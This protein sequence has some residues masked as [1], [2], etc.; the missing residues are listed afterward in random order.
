MDLSKLSYDE[1]IKKGVITRGSWNDD[2]WEVVD[3]AKWHRALDMAA[4]FHENAGSTF[5][6][7]SR[8]RLAGGKETPYIQLI[9]GVLRII[10]NEAKCTSDDFLTTSALYNIF[11]LTD[12]SED[13]V[14][15]EFGAKTAE[16]VKVLETGE[17]EKLCDQMM[18]LVKFAE[19][20]GE[21]QLVSCVFLAVKLFEER[22]SD[23]CPM[24]DWEED[25]PHYRKILESVQ[26]YGLR[27][28]EEK[29]WDIAVFLGHK[30]I[31]QLKENMNYS[32]NVNKTA[33]ELF[34]GWDD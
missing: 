29:K 32:R 31:E 6:D 23:V 11:K 27:I 15:G 5:V 20:S 19:D 9:Q 13:L 3:L 16:R 14:S 21:G 10:T 25:V 34:A 8:N 30:L 17:G 33:G 22:T 26:E 18:R 1:A 7:R 24:K 12:C 28:Y 2:E 4:K